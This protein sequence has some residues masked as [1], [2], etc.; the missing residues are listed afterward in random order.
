MTT[1]RFCTQ[2]IQRLR[3]NA[4]FELWNEDFDTLIWYDESISSPSESN[5]AD[6]SILLE[7]EFSCNEVRI[8]R[9]RLLTDTDWVVTKASETD[10]SVP[11]EWKTYRQALRDITEQSGFPDNVI[12]PP[13]PE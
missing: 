9:D 6:M 10:D 11:T 13:R 12:W 7:K 1:Y 8:K 2:A 3:P 4:S 5:V